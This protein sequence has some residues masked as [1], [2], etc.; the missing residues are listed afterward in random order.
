MFRRKG[1]PVRRLAAFCGACLMLLLLVP[2]PAAAELEL[3]PARIF[4]LERADAPPSWLFGTMHLT[5]P[6]IVALPPEAKHAFAQS[7]VIVGELDM[8]DFN[9]FAMLDDLM[10]P[11]DQSLRDLVDPELHRRALAELAALGLPAEF[12]DRFQV[13]AAAI[14]VAYDESEM[15]RVQQGIPA[16][17]EWLQ[18]EARR[19]GKAVIGLEEAE[20][21]LAI[22]RDL[23]LEWQV[24][25]LEVAL[26][27]PELLGYDDGP[28]KQMYL[29]GDHQGLW[30]FFAA[31]S[32]DFDSAFFAHFEQVALTDR[33]RRMAER[34]AP[35]LAEGGA[36]VSVGALH[37]P[38]PEG[39][40]VLL[41]A[42]GWEIVPLPER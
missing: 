29:A 19:Q 41:Q 14:L 40:F 5:D 16:L 3:P 32:G 42:E 35:I 7:R 25:M 33:N 1:D 34:L 28:L 37:L 10:L 8:A 22:F 6:A 18:Q 27:H 31:A 38:G 23:P 26:D 11:E 20:E 24:E 15:T 30:D 4:R 9:P 12:A 2:P 21:Q 13:W 36:F 17:D 39:L